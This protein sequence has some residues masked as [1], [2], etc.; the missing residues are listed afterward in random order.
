LSFRQSRHI[1]YGVGPYH[2][3]QQNVNR[4]L[5]LRDC[6]MYTYYGELVSTPNSTHTYNS[7]HSP[8]QEKIHLFLC[9]R[10]NTIRRNWSKVS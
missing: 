3:L 1:S 8:S 5:V 6:P 10:N 7:K 4:L 2:G 9:N